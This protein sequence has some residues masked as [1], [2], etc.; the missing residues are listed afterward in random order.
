ML[1]HPYKENKVIFPC[2]VQPKYDGIR[3]RAVIKDGVVTLWSR[4]NKPILSMQ[5]IIDVLSLVQEDIELDGELYTDQVSFQELNGIVRRQYSDERSTI[6]SY[7]IYDTI[8]PE[9]GYEGRLAKFTTVL[10]NYIPTS[11]TKNVKIVP[12]YTANKSDDIKA[13]HG[14]LVMAGYEGLMVRTKTVNKKTKEVEDTGYESDY[15][16]GKRRSW[17]LLKYKEFD[18]AEFEIVGLEEEYDLAGNP[19]GRLGAFKCALGDGRVFNA[20]GITDDIKK[21][22]WDNP[23]LYV[24]KKA[25]IKYFGLSQDGIPRFPNF[26]AIRWD[27]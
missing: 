27:D 20:S 2:Y 6:M 22:A 23:T 18:D 24:S 14:N 15:H 11:K 4:D 5:H 1:A 3:C 21:H 16:N 26:V 17:S 7:Y 19:K 8:A 25:T 10:G 9:M 13:W 12:T